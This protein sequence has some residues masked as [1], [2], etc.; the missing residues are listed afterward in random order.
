MF[1]DFLSPFTSNVEG[2]CYEQIAKT[3]VYKFTF[4]RCSW[5]SFKLLIVAVNTSR[6]VMKPI[7]K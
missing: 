4:E 6:E 5:S 3:T 7:P 2:Y 1:E